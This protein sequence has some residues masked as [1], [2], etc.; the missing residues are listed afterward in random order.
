[1]SGTKL[2]LTIDTP[3]LGGS[4]SWNAL[5]SLMVAMSHQLPARALALALEDAQER[6]AEAACGPC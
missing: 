5:E 6:L 1:V 2:A 3:E 4:L